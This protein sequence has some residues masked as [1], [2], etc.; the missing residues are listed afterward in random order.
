M[1]T[2]KP[3]KKIKA[4]VEIDPDTGKPSQV[5]FSLKTPSGGYY[6]SPWGFRKCEITYPI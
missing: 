3:L 5:L 4:W 2:P 6:G 1:T